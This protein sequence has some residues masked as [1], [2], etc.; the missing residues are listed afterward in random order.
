MLAPWHDLGHRSTYARSRRDHIVSRSHNRVQYDVNADLIRKSSVDHQRLQA[1]GN[2]L[3]NLPPRLQRYF[4]AVLHCDLKTGLELEY[5]PYPSLAE[6]F[7]HW[8]AGA[9]GWTSILH[10][11]ERIR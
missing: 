2:Y 5:I 9:S 11:L 3:Q 10:R 6:L 7:L 1:E 8:R 4:P